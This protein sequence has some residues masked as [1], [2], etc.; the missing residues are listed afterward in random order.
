MRRKF[1]HFLL[2]LIILHSSWAY[3]IFSHVDP[4]PYS[5]KGAVGA[6]AAPTI[7]EIT[8]G[9]CTLDVTWS[10]S[11]CPSTFD[12]FNI[13][14]QQTGKES[15]SEKVSYQTNQYNIHG[16]ISSQSYTVWVASIIDDAETNSDQEHESTEKGVPYDVSGIQTD[17]VSDS[18]INVSWQKTSNPCPIKG[19]EVSWNG[20][21]KFDDGLTPNGR[22]ETDENTTS[23]EI[24]NLVP[25]TTYNFYVSEI[26]TDGTIGN[27]SESSTVDTD[28]GA[29][30]APDPVTSEAL[31]PYSAQIHW[32]L[33]DA[34]NGVITG[35]HISCQIL[36][37]EHDD[38]DVEVGDDVFS[39]EVT[40]LL[41]CGEY[42]FSVQ[43]INAG[44]LGEAGTH[45]STT[46]AGKPGDI[47][48]F[49]YA[50]ITSDS[51][52]LI[53][54]NLTTNCPVT[55][56]DLH[57]EG[58]VLWNEKTEKFDKDIPEEDQY[59]LLEN[60]TPYTSYNISI[61]AT[62]KGGPTNYVSQVVETL[63]GVAAAPVDL[64]ASTIDDTSISLSWSES[65]AINGLLQGYHITC[66]KSLTDL[67]NDCDEYTGDLTYDVTGLDGCSDFNFNVAAVNRNGDGEGATAKSS[68]DNQTPGDM[69]DVTT[70]E[71]NSTNITVTVEPPETTCEVLHYDV[72]GTG[73]AQWNENLTIP[74]KGTLVKS[75]VGNTYIIPDV[76]PYTAYTFNI[77]ATTAGGT[78]NGV[79]YEETTAEGVP[80]EPANFRATVLDS[81][82]V[83][84]TWDEP[85][86]QNGDRLEDYYL[87]YELLGMES[88]E[89]DLGKIV[90][91]YT[92]GDDDSETLLPCQTYNIR[93]RASNENGIGSA[94]SLRAKLDAEE[95]NPV[96]RLRCNPVDSHSAELTWKVEPTTCRIKYYTISLN[97][98]IEWSNTSITVVNETNIPPNGGSLT[99]TDLIADTIYDITLQPGNDAGLGEAQSCQ[100]FVTDLDV[101]EKPEDLKVTDSSKSKLEINWLAPKMRNGVLTSF[102]ITWGENGQAFV[103]AVN[104][105]S[106]V[107][108]YSIEDLDDDK[109][110]EI[111]VSAGN[112]KGYGN[113]ATANGETEK[114]H[115]GAILGTVIPVIVIIIAVALGVWYNKSH[116]KKK[117]NTSNSDD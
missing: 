93:L 50:N 45:S 70:T 18:V 37:N 89:I 41:D 12:G 48:G 9:S 107:Y 85:E 46:D 60:L 30:S 97:G 90:K 42:T 3:N 16:L 58:K 52:F 23:I 109:I 63:E 36:P 75:G 59:F 21:A 71:A 95:P 101:P 87:S 1:L 55:K 64:T 96:A 34:A 81:R 116:K 103:D 7:S 69:G 112:S 26:T 35:Y 22:R 4:K 88:E 80:S 110:Y 72:E 33:P 111:K 44:G 49:S 25:Y 76:N 32:T 54:D 24:D 6:S 61:R 43:A 94:A 47:T 91:T 104:D 67:T 56:Y 79:P 99:L 5:R 14:W 38:C 57:V 115:L 84:L 65:P 108:S 114:S 10:C 100:Q 106:N 39:Y 98:N 29:A 86:F 53:W 40:T 83:R 2:F 28:E 15:Q 11:S 117:K 77:S 20:I 19:Y 82:R 74:Y 27:F 66:K 62:T 68:T 13:Y 92:L 113:E 51:I 78:T 105:I 73:V 8:P 17:T 31:G 102:K